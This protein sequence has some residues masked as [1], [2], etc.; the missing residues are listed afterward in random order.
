MDKINVNISALKTKW[1]PKEML[2][3]KGLANSVIHKTWELLL[4][5]KKLSIFKKK[6]IFIDVVLTNDQNMIKYNFRFRGKKLATNVISL[7]FY[8][9]A[10]FNNQLEQLSLGSIIISLE[11]LLQEALQQ[12]MTKENHFIRLLVHGLLHLLGYDHL[13]N[14]DS[15]IM[16]NLENKILQN[17]NIN[18]TSIVK[19][20]W[21]EQ[22]NNA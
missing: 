14:K 12:N 15:T 6:I 21:G 4:K 1:Q 20:Y 8:T 18:E 19:N 17:L 3:L 13:N 22:K 5:E 10:D 16:Y 2:A 7:Q 11:T 9:K